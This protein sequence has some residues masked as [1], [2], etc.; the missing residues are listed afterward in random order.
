MKRFAALIAA[1]DQTANADDRVAELAT[2]FLAVTEQDRLWAIALLTGRRPRRIARLNDLRD[3][4]LAAADVPLWL[5]EAARRETGDLAEAT[6]LLLPPARTQSAYENDESL[7]DW[8]T[9]LDAMARMDADSLRLAVLAAWQQLR[10]DQRLLFNK[11]MTGEFRTGV[12]LAEMAQS[13]SQVTGLGQHGLFCR[14]AQHWFPQGTTFAEF[15]ST[16]DAESRAGYPYPFGGATSLTGAAAYLGQP[17][18]WTADW[19]WDGIRVQLVLRDR[20]RFLWSANGLLTDSFPELVVA[21]DF[22]PQGTVIE[23]EIVGWHDG[24]LPVT[25][26]ARRI[27]AK[28]PSRREL[29]AH[30]VMLIADDLLEWQ[31][32]D[33]R[34]RP[35]HD[36]RALLAEAMAALPV[37]APMRLAE[38]LPFAGWQQLELRHGRAREIGASGM[39]L[40]RRSAAVNAGS[41]GERLIWPADPL[42]VAAVLVSALF[43]RDQRAT[44]AFAVWDGD[45][46]VPIT[47]TDADLTG[48]ASEISTWVSRNT[49]GRYGP[50]RQVTPELVF[51]LAFDGVEVSPR[52]KAGLALRAA[53]AVT[54]HRDLTARD[55]GRLQGLRAMLDYQTLQPGEL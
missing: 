2:Y 54:W 43:G 6:A 22:L 39:T 49:I 10:P 4:A 19:A 38:P 18:D 34:D 20:A 29:A 25:S 45:V 21:Q 7:T 53:R 1:L 12:S 23:G 15:V 50:A 33:I 51:D 13:L 28:R 17:A 11:L 14:L 35:F 37:R 55:A 16:E 48:A 41:A 46:L 36:R 47:K 5:F 40:R 26:L 32:Q 3:W 27:A 8:I 42:R 30:P 24:V 52:H 44:Y 31:G 9:R